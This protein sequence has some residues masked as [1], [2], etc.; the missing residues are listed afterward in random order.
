[1]YKVCGENKLKLNYFGSAF[2]TLHVYSNKLL[3]KYSR[4]SA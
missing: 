2:E 1:M 4:F 3:F